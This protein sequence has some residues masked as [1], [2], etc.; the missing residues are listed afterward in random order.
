MPQTL[1]PEWTA[2]L[3]DD[4]QNHWARLLHTLGNL[5]LTGYNADLSNRPY[6][7]K[8]DEYG[9][10][11]FELNRAFKDV[12]RWTPSAI[13]N[14]GR[15]LAKGALEIWPDLARPNI[16]EPAGRRR[17]P[18]PVAVRFRNDTE[19]VA[20]WKKAAVRL[21]EY[22][23]TASPGLLASVEKKNELAYLLSRDPDRFSRS[24]VQIG[25][26]HVQMHASASTLR[27]YVV[28]LAQKAGFKPDEYEFILP[29][30]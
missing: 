6:H 10:S 17:T 15:D 2:E 3:G 30:S 25:G 29:A 9:K 28:I 13:E 16:P 23:E 20:T 14:R 18:P 7:E 5:T 4:A 1:T 12:E 19:P 11:H 27:A 22:F 26:I 21:I 8:R 24:N